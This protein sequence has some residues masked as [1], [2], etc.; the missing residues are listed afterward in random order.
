MARGLISH[1][2]IPVVDDRWKEKDN[3]QPRYAT[4]RFGWSFV[5]FFLPA[6]M[7]LVFGCLALTAKHKPKTTTGST[8]AQDYF[9]TDV[10]LSPGLIEN[11][12][13]ENMGGLTTARVLVL[14]AGL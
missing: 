11:K 12:L 7:S 10:R 1:K 4:L 9:L 13:W 8:Q 6:I 5:V 3:D 14:L 2:E